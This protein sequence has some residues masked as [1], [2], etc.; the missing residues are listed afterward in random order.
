MG[1]PPPQYY[2][3]VPKQGAGGCRAPPHTVTVS[4]ARSPPPSPKKAQRGGHGTL[5]KDTCNLQGAPRWPWG[6]PIL[7]HYKTTI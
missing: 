1:T 3:L 4:P 2:L 5:Q 7:R 6:S